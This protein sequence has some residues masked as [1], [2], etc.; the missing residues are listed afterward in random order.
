MS[1][2]IT[3]LFLGMLLLMS[4]QKEEDE[5]INRV[6]ALNPFDTIE[7]NNS[8]DV[9]LIEDSVFYLE[10]F[11]TK[12]NLDKLDIK[13]EGQ[14]L[15]IS[16][17]KRLKWTSPK[18]NPIKL[19][20]HSKPLKRVNANETCYIQSLNP[21]SSKEFGI[22]LQSKANTAELDLNCE[23]FYYWNNFPCGGKLS[24]RGQVDELK[25]W[26]TAIMTVDAQ[27]LLCNYALVENSSQGNCTVNVLNR[28]DYKINGSG[29]IRVYGS[30]GEI[31][32]L[33][34][35]SSGRLILY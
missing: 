18:G 22:V 13:V 29:D 10:A 1:K 16:N 15:I 14:S 12:S 23:V 26:N 33:P 34:S 7:L 25:L 30:P 5:K 35:S 31:N 17:T 24:L 28:L 21:I 9:F 2:F 3:Y 8:F 6:L 11:G 19:K 4:C 27:N 20:I 32:Q